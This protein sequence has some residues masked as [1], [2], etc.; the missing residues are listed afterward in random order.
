[1]LKKTLTVI[2]FLFIF[3]LWTVILMAVARV[4]FA[5]LWNFDIFSSYS[6][7]IIASFWDKGGKINTWQDYTF[8]A[9]LI[10]LIP[11]WILGIRK[12]MNINFLKMFLT[13]VVYFMNRGLDEA[14]KS[15]TIKNIDVSVSKTSKEEML[16]K[17][18]SER[19]KKF[20]DVSEEN[21]KSFENIRKELAQKK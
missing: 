3:S 13:P 17:I 15:V 19:M 21:E 1:M 20:D 9:M 6:W 10:S 18:V 5:K 16:E 14:P 8:F 4:L 12:G 7:S 11:F 2:K